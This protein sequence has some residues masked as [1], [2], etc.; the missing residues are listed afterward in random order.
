MNLTTSTDV[1]DFEAEASRLSLVQA[2]QHL[3]RDQSTSLVSFN[4][5]TGSSSSDHPSDRIVSVLA[6]RTELVEDDERTCILLFRVGERQLS[7]AADATYQILHYKSLPESVMRK[8]PGDTR[9]E[10]LSKGGIALTSAMSFELHQPHVE[11]LFQESN[12]G[13]GSG[14]DSTYYITCMC[15]AHPLLMSSGPRQH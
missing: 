8:A 7:A 1:Q 13:L 11:V 5:T 12:K 4:A 9:S 14:G 6:S 2:R 10:S 15:R 3:L